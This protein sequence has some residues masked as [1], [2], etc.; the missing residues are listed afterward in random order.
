MKQMTKNENE[1]VD[2][3]NHNTPLVKDRYCMIYGYI[4]TVIGFLI[5]AY[6]ILYISVYYAINKDISIDWIFLSFLSVISILSVVTGIQII[7]VKVKV[8]PLLI[9][10]LSL[11]LIIIAGYIFD[12]TRYFFDFGYYLCIF[13]TFS[14]AG[15][16]AAI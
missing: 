11:Y 5:F 2:I 1:V 14:I 10:T 7:R 3:K 13:I 6:V 16:F 15:F 9:I 12:R 4:L 8:L